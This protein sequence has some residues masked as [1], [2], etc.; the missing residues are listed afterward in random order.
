MSEREADQIR[1][2]WE[3]RRDYL[4]PRLI[5]AGRWNVQRK[6]RINIS[7]K[8]APEP[9]P[10]NPHEILTFVLEWGQ[11]PMHRQWRVRCGDVICEYGDWPA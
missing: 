3:D 1:E 4:M 10:F 6:P 9:T 8:P 7:L 11:P 5:K 2:I